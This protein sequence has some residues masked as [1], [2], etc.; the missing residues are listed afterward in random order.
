MKKNTGSP[1]KCTTRI[2]K[3]QATV[4]VSDKQ[5]KNKTQTTACVL[6]R[7]REIEREGER[8]R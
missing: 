7:V 6:T 8:E 3:T 1:G 4:L 5:L 2:H